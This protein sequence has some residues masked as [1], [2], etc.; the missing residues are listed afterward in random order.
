MREAWI[1]QGP[2]WCHD[3]EGDDGARV[4]AITNRIIAARAVAETNKGGQE[5]ERARERRS[6]SE[7]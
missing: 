3:G 6:V 7:G 5:S 4:P 1:H 2:D